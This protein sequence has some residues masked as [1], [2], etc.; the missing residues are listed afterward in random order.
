MV[1]PSQSLAD[2]WKSGT[3]ALDDA[4]NLV[5]DDEELARDRIATALRH[6]ET[7]RYIAH[8]IGSENYPIDDELDRLANLED[9]L[10]VNELDESSPLR[11][12]RR[13]D[14][15]IEVGDKAFDEGRPEEAAVAYTRAHDILEEFLEEPIGQIDSGERC[16]FC[17]NRPWTTTVT[18]GGS[19]TSVC[20]RCKN[21]YPV[22]IRRRIASYERQSPF[23]KTLRICWTGYRGRTGSRNTKIVIQIQE[24]VHHQRI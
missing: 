10:S 14:R 22:G 16:Q 2:L 12:L 4:S 19:E 13:S 24:T 9:D 3:D 20:S 21:G 5:D 1:T 23:V 8:E 15:E 18:F 11:K 7:A 17:L 6:L